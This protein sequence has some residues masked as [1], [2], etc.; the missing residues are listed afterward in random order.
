VVY[1]LAGDKEMQEITENLAR[2]REKIAAAA[3]KS[4]RKAEEILLVAVSKGVEPERIEQAIGA[5]VTDLGENY[6]QEAIGKKAQVKSKARWHFIGHLQRNKVQAALEEFSLI[7]SVD[8]LKLAQEISRRAAA[9]GKIAQILLQVNTSS[10]TS[11]F[12]VAPEETRRLVEE[13]AVL[14]GLS[15]QGLMTIGRFEPDPEA[16]RGEF[17][18]LSKIFREISQLNLPN[19]KMRWLSMGM[20]HDFEV[21]IEEGANLVRIGTGIFG[22]RRERQ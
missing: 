14:P 3:A 21:A 8:S 4:G 9:A 20:T 22:P 15:L 16:A 13:I 2:I 7:Q 5:G 11:K 10:E 1:S 18:L 19:I 17:R 6:L 12:G